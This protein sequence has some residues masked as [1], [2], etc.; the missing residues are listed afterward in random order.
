MRYEDLK[1][2][3]TLCDGTR[4][5]GADSC[6]GTLYN[7]KQCGAVGCKQS[8]ED[9]CSHQGFNVLGHCLKCRAAGQMEAIPAGDYAPQQAWL[10]GSQS[11]AS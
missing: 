2:D 9:L 5:G 4:K 7:C 11:S 1:S 3:L 8:R 10:S 6:R